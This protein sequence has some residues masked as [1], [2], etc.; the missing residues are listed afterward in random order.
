MKNV[1]NALRYETLTAIVQKLPVSP[2]NLFI[3]MF[4]TEQADSDT[5]RW[6]A[7]YGAVGMTP[8]AAP[9][10][11]APVTTDDT[12]WSEGSARAAFYKEKRYFGE[13]FLN[14]LQDPLNVTKRVSA[15]T[16]L[17]KNM[18]KMNYRCDRRREWMLAQMLFRGGFTY[19]QEKGIRL[20]VDYGIPATHKLTLTGNDV[21]GT[22]STRNPVEDIFD[23]KKLLNDDAGVAP[24]NVI[25]TTEVV[26]LLMFDTSVQELLKKS[27][28]GDGDLFSKPA[29]VLGHLLGVGDLKTY[30]ALYEIRSHLVTTASATNTFV[31]EDVTDMEVGGT[32]RLVDM[33]KNRVWE[34]LVIQTITPAT[35]TITTTANCTGT[36]RGQRDV[37]IMKRRFID[38]YAFMM[39][40]STAE[41]QKIA[42]FME[43]PYGMP[44]KFGK[45]ADSKPEWDPD[46]IWIRVQ[47][48]GLPVLYNPE[49]IVTLKVK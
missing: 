25:T 26:K 30:D 6:G 42:K 28:F 27:A 2:D 31:V 20:N 45:F 10:A 44:R 8:F 36:Y 43:A 47:D 11:P 18:Q 40:S 15:E 35:N 22:G 19:T 3:N 17:A 23:M 48:K 29:A 24:D 9:G 21:W 41:G 38:P 7:E 5:V 14:N 13:E 33:S 37:V 32:L 4:G 12:F 39:F 49:T 34:D 1:P 16:T 46:G